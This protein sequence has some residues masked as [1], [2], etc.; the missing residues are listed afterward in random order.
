MRPNRKTTAASN[1]DRITT[2]SSR[3]ME[4]ALASGGVI[5]DRVKLFQRRIENGFTT[6]RK[7]ATKTGLSERTINNAEAEK[8]IR[9]DSADLI[10]RA[11]HVPL[12]DL[13]LYP[14]SQQLLPGLGPDQN[15]GSGQ[16]SAGP[17]ISIR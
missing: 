10:A 7:L 4:R 16:P 9:A 3:Q 6:Q 8:C 15:R 17:T 5:L 1:Q 14:Q 11:L 2:E 12:K 13:L